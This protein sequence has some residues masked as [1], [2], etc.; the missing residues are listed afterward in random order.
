[1]TLEMALVAPALLVLILS[2]VQF[3]LWYYAG[4]V[5]RAAAR[6]GA[7]AGA[8]GAGGPA[9]AEPAARA[10]VAGPGGGGAVHVPEVAV[11]TDAGAETVTVVVSGEAPSL[12]LGLRLPVRASATASAETFRR[13]P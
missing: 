3:S 7:N 9:A 1:V 13:A 2:C 12:V 6:E 4:S 10:V 5:V 8:E 11:S